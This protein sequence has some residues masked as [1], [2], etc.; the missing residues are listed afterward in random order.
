MYH[1]V[2]IY[3]YCNNIRLSCHRS[4]PKEQQPE[5]SLNPCPY[6][7]P[8]IHSLEPVR[9]MPSKMPQHLFQPPRAAQVALLNHLTSPYAEHGQNLPLRLGTAAKILFAKV[10]LPRGLRV[11]QVVDVGRLSG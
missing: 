3:S 7:H 10:P 8:L 9:V 11:S 2:L 5:K 6:S 4:R 1:G